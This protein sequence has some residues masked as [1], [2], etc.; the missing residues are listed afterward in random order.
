MSLCQGLFD[1]F[2][3]VVTPGLDVVPHGLA[4][5]FNVPIGDAIKYRQMLSARALDALT[6][7]EVESPEDRESVIDRLQLIE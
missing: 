1:D 7:L 2:F 5:T 6:N 3:N 4:R